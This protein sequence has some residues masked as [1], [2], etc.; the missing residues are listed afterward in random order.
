MPQLTKQRIAFLKQEWEKFD[1][2]LDE[3]IWEYALS[4]EEEVE[5][6]NGFISLFINLPEPQVA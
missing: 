2:S 1:G 4:E 5:V 3:F 6:Q